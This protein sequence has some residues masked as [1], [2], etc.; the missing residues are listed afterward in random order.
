MSRRLLR[1]V[2]EG[3]SAVNAL[4]LP[5]STTS[6][7]VEGGCYDPSSWGSAKFKSAPNLQPRATSLDCGCCPIGP[8]GPFT[9][10]ATIDRR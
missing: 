7:I 3:E 10:S 4:D 9:L 8:F 6:Q 2:N 5:F 1:N